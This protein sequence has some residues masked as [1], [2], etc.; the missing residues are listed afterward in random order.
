M[1]FQT[2][3]PVPQEKEL[4]DTAFRRA[5]VKGQQKKL[6]GDWLQ[7]VRQKEILKLEVVKESFISKLEN[8][9]RNFP[10]LEELPVFYQELFKATLDVDK[11]KKYL[12]SLLWARKQIQLLYQRIKQSIIREKDQLKIKNFCQQGYGRFASVIKQ[13]SPGLLYLESARK[14]M[15]TYPDVK[16]MFTV[17]I[18][19]FP[20]VGKSTLLNKLTGT[21]AEVAPY[22]FTTK[23]INVG[24]MSLGDQKIQ[25]MDVPGT[26]ARPEK[27]NNIELQAEL[28][29]LHLANAV[30]YVFDPSEYS[31]YSI[32]DQ[33]KL[34]EKVR[35]RKN[36]LLYYS[37]M[38]L[39]SPEIMAKLNEKSLSIPEIKEE[40]GV[41]LSKI[42]NSADP[43]R[44]NES[45]EEGD[46]S[47]SSQ[48]S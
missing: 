20:N 2:L 48:S 10:R 21:K 23:S 46:E 40:L 6:T 45:R 19:G 33:L 18:Y 3:P 32:S 25:L 12:A 17:C 34:L 39:I 14:V 36:V 47:E 9:G 37:K 5:R 13:V 15:K 29:L 1:N 42:Y 7:K 43:S 44:G 41:L 26:L 28:V 16:E 22:A 24:Y 27:M 30:I 38:D 11:F 35:E 4:I 31:G 8:V